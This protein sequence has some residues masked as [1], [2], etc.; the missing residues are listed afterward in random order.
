MKWSSGENKVWPW[1]RWLEFEFGR[2][3]TGKIDV[4]VFRMCGRW[5]DKSFPDSIFV[6]PYLST[7]FYSYHNLPIRGFSSMGGR[8]ILNSESCPKLL[9][10]FKKIIKIV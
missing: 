7:F 9:Q 6:L 5:L 2:R 4:G 3:L 1:R 10:I 8:P